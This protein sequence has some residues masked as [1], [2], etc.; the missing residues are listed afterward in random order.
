M[1]I[2]EIIALT[3]E[4]EVKTPRAATETPLFSPLVC[5]KNAK[6]H[7][8]YPCDAFNFLLEKK[9]SLGIQDVIMFTNL[10]VDGAIALA[11]GRRLA[12]EIKYRMNWKKALEAEFEFRQHLRM[13]EAK[14]SGGIVL[15][16]QFQGSQW[17]KQAQSRFLENGWNEWYRSFSN[18][19]GHPFHLIRF[20]RERDIM[21]TGTLEKGLEYY[22]LALLNAQAKPLLSQ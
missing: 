8:K 17:E 18:I 11:D 22:H 4:P 21:V 2:A 19:D 16:E 14:V 5:S 10:R 7:V 12:V 3:P 13:T 15:F 6:P 1:T 9:V 20:H